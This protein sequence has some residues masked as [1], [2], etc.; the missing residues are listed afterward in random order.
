MKFEKL[1]KEMQNEIVKEYLGVL[2]K[3]KFSFFLKRIFDFLASI[4]MIIILSP[5]LIILSV[6]IKWTSKGPV[7]YKQKRVTKYCRVFNIYKFR[8]MVN[9]ADKIGSQVTINND[10]RITKVGKFLRKYRLD[11]LP[12]LFNIIIGDMSFV[13]PRPEVIKYVEKYTD[14]MYATLLVRAGVTSPA[15]IK[16]KDEMKL[17]KQT[18][19]VDYTYINKVLPDKMTYNYQYLLTFNL[20]KDLLILLKTFLIIIYKGNNKK[21]E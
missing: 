20:F 7:I 15:S 4:I 10:I 13:G 6:I 1:P 17:L 12:Q 2:N 14:E 21:N 11:E 3:K 9:N 8:T 18:E 5:L 16:Y 19:D